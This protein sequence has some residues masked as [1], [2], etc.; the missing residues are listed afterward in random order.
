MAKSS[1]SAKSER[2][3]LIDSAMKKQRSAEKRQSNLIV[4]IAFMAV[5]FTYATRWE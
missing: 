4:G 2:Q 5:G 1:K 3:A